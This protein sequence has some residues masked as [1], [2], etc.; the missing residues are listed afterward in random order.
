ML[1]EMCWGELFLFGDGL[2]CRSVVVFGVVL[3][4]RSLE[5]ECRK[6]RSSFS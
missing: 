1:E 2:C 5:G 6:I 4:E 3:R